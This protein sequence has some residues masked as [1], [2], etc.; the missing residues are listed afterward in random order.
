MMNLL[1]IPSVVGNSVGAWRHPD[2]WRNT[3]MSFERINELAQIAERGKLDAIFLADGNGV[4]QLD[5]LELLAATSPSDRPAVFEPLTLLSALAT[6]TKH[7][8]LIAT[9]T[10]TYDEPYAVARRFASL[11]HLSNGRAGWN[12]VTTSAPDDALNFSYSEH[13]ERGKRYDRASEFVDVVL[14]LWDSWAEDAFTQDQASGQFLNPKRLRVLNHKGEHFAVRGPLNIARP[15]QGHPVIFNAGQS[16]AGLELAARFADCVF[17]ITG[18]IAAAEK[19]SSNLR[20]R[21]GKYGHN[22]KSLKIIPSATIFVGRTEEDADR[23]AKEIS[24]LISP[25]IGVSYLSKAVGED[26]SKYDVDGP[27]PD[28][29]GEILGFQGMRAAIIDMAHKSNMTIRQTYQRLVPARGLL[30]FKGDAKQIADQMANWYKSGA[31]D[32]FMVSPPIAPGGLTRFVDLVVPEL[33]SRGIFRKE[34]EGS[35]LRDIMGL[36]RPVNAYFPD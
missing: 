13:M 2:A 10:T 11:D 21:R 29:K 17:A 9:S 28:L 26:L 35:T 7:V 24:E 6:Q 22:E 32:G 3:V 5:N 23:L 20:G 14:Q 1:T 18:D 36:Q 8:G 15:P 33:Q 30:I 19:F 31:C 4:R 12:V 34:Y 25:S 16:E 27:F